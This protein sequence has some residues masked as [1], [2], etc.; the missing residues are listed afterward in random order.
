MTRKTK[1]IV[2]SIGL[3]A[4]AATPAA[5]AAKTHHV[6]T[7]H[8]HVAPVAPPTY[9]WQGGYGYQSNYGGVRPPYHPYYGIHDR[10]TYGLGD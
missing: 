7:Y 5:A 1:L 8:S 3:L 10:Q 6:R 9:G 4:I 2:G